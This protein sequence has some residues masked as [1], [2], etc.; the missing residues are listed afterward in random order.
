MVFD[1]VCNKC[2]EDRANKPIG[3]LSVNDYKDQCLALA[4]RVEHPVG[5]RPSLLCEQH[6]VQLTKCNGLETAYVRGYGYLDKRAVQNDM[7]LHSMT[8]GRD[9][10]A[11][12]RKSGDS[13]E[14]IGK[15]RRNKRHRPKTSDVFMR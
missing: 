7:N 4:V 1:Y 2:V 11:A 13:K 15:L 6:N 9:P 3:S 10:Y 5:E 14:L 8:E 12:H